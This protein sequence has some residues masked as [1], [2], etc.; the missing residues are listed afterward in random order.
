MLEIRIR[1]C[2]RAHALVQW[3]A[4]RGDSGTPAASEVWDKPAVPQAALV[5][6]RLRGASA[7]V[8]SLNACG[9]GIGGAGVPRQA[10]D[11]EEVLDLLAGGVVDFG[12]GAQC[13]AREAAL[14]LAGVR[15]A[16]VV[17]G[18]EA[19]HGQRPA[20]LVGMVWCC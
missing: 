1:L 7:I 14:L 8:A 2:S 3:V 18:R 6:L 15:H 4:L 13:L 20:D 12:V 11:A 16:G 10:V 9:L 19:R 5:V 17:G